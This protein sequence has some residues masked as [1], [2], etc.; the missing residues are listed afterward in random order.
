MR[1]MRL[2]S[3][4]M[5]HN[6]AVA[7]RVSLVLVGAEGV[8]ENGGII[9]KL[10]TYQLAICA[11]THGIPFYAAAESYKVRCI[12]PMTPRRSKQPSSSFFWVL[13]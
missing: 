5:D 10:G 13:L 11:K 6:A 7:R 3:V 2:E 9:N 12:I 8:V 4:N 1:S